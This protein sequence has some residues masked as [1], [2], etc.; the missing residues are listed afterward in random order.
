MCSKQLSNNL[1][2]LLEKKMALN[3]DSVA[4]HSCLSKQIN[5]LVSYNICRYVYALFYAM[6]CVCKICCK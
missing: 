6:Q 4:T 2:V 5:F 1:C 3:C